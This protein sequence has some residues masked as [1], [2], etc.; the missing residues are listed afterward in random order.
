MYKRQ[1]DNRD[2]FQRWAQATRDARDQLPEFYNAIMALDQAQI[3]IWE[4]NFDSAIANVDDASAMFGKSVLQT[5]LDDL[6]ASEIFVN[7][8]RL[9]LEAGAVDKARD[10][11]EAVLRVNPSYAYG[12]F[13]LARVLTAAGDVDNAR[14]FLEEAMSLWSEAD[15]EFLYLQ[16]ARELMASLDS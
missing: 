6:G 5:L 1:A 15:E 12:K 13:M 14:L 11:L 2:E 3:D 4:E 10:Q 16:R 7:I 9:Y 8:A